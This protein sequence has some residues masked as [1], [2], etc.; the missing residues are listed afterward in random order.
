M[1]NRVLAL[2]YL[3]RNYEREE[4]EEKIS[5]IL[6]EEVF[7]NLPVVENLEPIVLF[8]FLVYLSC[9]PSGALY[10]EEGGRQAV[11]EPN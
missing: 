5:F 2:S 1:A 11:A 7:H 6:L 10:R 8:F 3:G 4:E 9:L